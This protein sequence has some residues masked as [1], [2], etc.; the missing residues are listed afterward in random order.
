MFLIVLLFC[1]TQIEARC[2]NR[3]GGISECSY[4]RPQCQ[5]GS[6]G[7][8]C[9]DGCTSG[10]TLYTGPTCLNMSSSEPNITIRYP[11]RCN[12]SMR[13]FE[14]Y[15]E[16]NYKGYG[17]VCPYGC[18]EQK[19]TCAHVNMSDSNTICKPFID[20][21]C[22][23]DCKYIKSTNS[24]VPLNDNSVCEFI[25]NIK[26]CPVGCNYDNNYNRCISNDQNVVCRLERKLVCPKFCLLNFRG[27]KCISSTNPVTP[28]VNSICEYTEKPTCP[29]YC[30]Y[31]DNEKVCRSSLNQN[32][33]YYNAICEPII[34][35]VCPH[36]V[37]NTSINVLP[38]SPTTTHDICFTNYPFY[39]GTIQYPLRL[40]DK[41]SNIKCKY[42]LVG[43]CETR[44]IVHECCP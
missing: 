31:D 29:T 10:S 6:I 35:S 21:V 8:L 30:Y 36:Y 19:N 38:C 22:P 24:C 17:T 16:C 18:I 11:N 2:W 37:Y 14:T 20:W 33:H 4:L 7:C 28:G 43:N 12:P 9:A 41:Y 34:T 13:D 25:P 40:K 27:D 44:R 1:I 15:I 32:A 42:S 39:P 23:Y 5:P 26:R 3:T